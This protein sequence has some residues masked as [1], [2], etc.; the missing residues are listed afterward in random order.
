MNIKIKELKL[1]NFKGISKRTLK[2]DDNRTNIFGANE[3]GKTTIFDAFNWLLFG[4][5]SLDRADYE[6]KTLDQNNEAKHKLTHSV[7]GVF[8][9]DNRKLVLKRELKEKWVKPHG[10]P[11]EIFKGHETN[12]WVDGVPQAKAKDYSD[13]IATIIGES[14][15]K[16]ITNPYYF[17]NMHWTKRREI[18]LKVAGEPTNEAIA[19]GVQQFEKL[20]LLLEGRT[21]EDYLKIIAA[22]KKAI[23]ADIQDIPARI[24]ELERSKPQI[25]DAVQV[26]IDIAK[27][28]ADIVKINEAVANQRQ[29]ADKH[30]NPYNEAK[31]KLSDLNYQLSTKKASSVESDATAV[32]KLGEITQKISELKF[33]KQRLE[34]SLESGKSLIYESEAKLKEVSDKRNALRNKFTEV[35]VSQFVAN[36]DELVCPNCKRPYDDTDTTIEEMK[37]K[38]NEAKTKELE[39]INVLGK[40]YKEQCEILEVKIATYKED[41]ETQKVALQEVVNSIAEYELQIPALQEA[42]KP[43]IVSC[44]TTSIEKEINELQEFVNNFKSFESK[45][46]S[47]EL[48]ALNDAKTQLKLNLSAVDTI[49]TINERITELIAK[50]KMLSTELAESEGI[51]YIASQFEKSKIEM[52]ETSI[53]EKFGVKFKMFNQLI[54]GGYEPACEVLINGVPFAAANHAA[55]INTGIKI[56]NAF[57]NHNNITAPIFVDNAEAVNQIEATESQL[58]ALVVVPEDYKCEE[59]EQNILL[60]K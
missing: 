59:N 15:F 11:E 51:E 44:D 32:S 31:K 33:S 43:K 53:N 4:K 42:A 60:T 35:S 9:I 25:I 24:D 37:A 26:E 22:K 56:I 30:F 1:E 18:V 23:K 36:P 50:Q 20:L 47:Q 54:N 49:N 19:K 34:N 10:E 29:E 46:Y 3:A 40:S 48:S 7:E 27:I 58:I 41:F 52:M 28:D 2:F 6:I 39:G 17:N 12:Y 5:D 55:Q 21:I 14:L 57:A 13:I 8:M 45:D 16:L 38:F